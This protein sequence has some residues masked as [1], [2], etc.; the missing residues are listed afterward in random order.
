MFLADEIEDDYGD[1][2]EEYQCHG[3]AKINSA[4]RALQILNVNGDST[5]LIDIKHK[6]RQEIVIPDPHDFQNANGNHSRFQH[7]K[8]NVEERAQRATAINRRRLFNLQRN[9]FYKTDEHKDGKPCT[10]A[11]IDNRN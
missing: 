10:E 4:V 3:C 9:G 8:N 1:N 5:V 11:Q 2:A 7:G 6:I